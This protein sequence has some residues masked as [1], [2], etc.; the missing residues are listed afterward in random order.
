[1]VGWLSEGLIG[2]LNGWMV[3]RGLIGGLNGLMVVRKVD[4]LLKWFGWLSAG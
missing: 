2:C 4:W 3:V 1:M